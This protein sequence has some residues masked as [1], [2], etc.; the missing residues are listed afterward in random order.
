[1]LDISVEQVASL[2]SQNSLPAPSLDLS[3]L[4]TSASDLNLWRQNSQN[5]P[6]PAYTTSA[7]PWDVNPYANPPRPGGSGRQESASGGIL[8]GASGGVVGTGL[9]SGWWN[10]QES[11]HVNVKGQQG[12]ILKR[13]M[14]YEVVSE[15]S[16]YPDCTDVS[17]ADIPGSVVG[18][19]H[20]A[21]QSSY[22]CGNALFAGIHSGMPSPLFLGITLTPVVTTV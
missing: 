2:A 18:L 1:M 22:S 10:K 20:A 5:S 3:T 7:D 19:Y 17:L 21:I 6:A 16:L 14:V 13:Y 11:V 9:P 12:F 4:P 15:V 8:N